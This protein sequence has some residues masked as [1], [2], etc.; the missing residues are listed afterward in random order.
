MTEDFSQL[1]ALPIQ[2]HLAVHIQIQSALGGMDGSTQ[3]LPFFQDGHEEG[4]HFVSMA[5]VLTG[6]DFLHH[7]VLG[8]THDLA[9]QVRGLDLDD[10]PPILKDLS[11]FD[12]QIF[13]F[14]LE[15]KSVFH[16]HSSYLL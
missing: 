10:V 12:H 1:L 7:R 5:S 2:A 9:P 6:S 4:S 3:F 11:G 14:I 16:I 13:E 8:I 15:A